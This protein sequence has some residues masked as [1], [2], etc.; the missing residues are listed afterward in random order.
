[1]TYRPPSA[2][3]RGR[4]AA[5]LHQQRRERDWSQQQAFEALHEGLG[6]GPRSRASYVALDMGDRQPKPHEAAFLGSYFGAEPSN[7]D[8]PPEPTPDL[9]TALL[10]LVE[11]LGEMRKERQALATKV[12]EL[13]AAVDQLVAAD[14]D[15]RGNEGPSTHGA[16]RP[17]G[18]AGL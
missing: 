13:S 9:A 2:T 1:M 3:P 7:E 14:L 10:A 11:E 12:E 16:H 18:A 5:F 17:T 15:R 6:L 8:A 4:W